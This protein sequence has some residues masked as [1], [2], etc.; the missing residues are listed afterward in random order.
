MVYIKSTIDNQKC[1]AKS[2]HSPSIPTNRP[3]PPTSR[4]HNAP[5]YRSSAVGYTHRISQPT[6]RSRI[7]MN[8]NGIGSSAVSQTGLSPTSAPSADSVQ[9]FN[10][11]MS[12]QG[13]QC[14]GAQG[15]SGQSGQS[16][17]SGSTSSEQSDTMSQM[18][19]MIMQVLQS[20]IEQMQGADSSSTGDQSS[21]QQ[22]ASNQSA[23]CGA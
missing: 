21:G 17:Q 11:A 7:M 5:F 15:A 13:S 4:L 18:M 14:S 9:Q 16:G 2:T 12:G 10:H 3:N 6:T 8:I 23:T 1:F 22:Q 19:E 20:M